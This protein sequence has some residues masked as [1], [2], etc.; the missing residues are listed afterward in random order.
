MNVVGDVLAV[1]RRVP[2]VGIR[3]GRAAAGLLAAAEQ[4]P[5]LVARGDAV[6]ARAEPFV[7][8]ADAALSHAEALVARAGE[9]AERAD[10]TAAGVDA[11][12]ADAAAATREVDALR[13]RADAL[14][15]AVEPLVATVS[16]VD[17]DLP[18]EASRL[19]RRALPPVTELA[20]LMPLL[21]EVQELLVDVET[22]FAGLPGAGLLRRRGERELEDTAA[23]E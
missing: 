7:A 1:P 2:G 18:A 21:R 9:I 12:R 11:V 16:A 15:G 23:H 6:L 22:R 10:R 19:V 14:L 13:R 5:L 4:V 3:V 8:L 20:D 17:P